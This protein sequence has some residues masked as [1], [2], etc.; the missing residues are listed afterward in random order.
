MK[1]VL[2]KSEVLAILGKHF[3][4]VLDDSKVFI[5]TNPDLEIEL[6]GIQMNEEPV[7]EAP[8]KTRAPEPPAV[9]ERAEEIEE[10]LVESEKLKRSDRNIISAVPSDFSDE[11]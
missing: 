6:R 3:G 11:V 8:K 10:V 4:T 7:E 2:E 9:K 5:T 1:I